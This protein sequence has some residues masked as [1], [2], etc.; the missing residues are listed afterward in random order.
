M[1]DTS[2]IARPL[3]RAGPARHL[4]GTSPLAVAALLAVVLGLALRL[5]A[6]PDMPFWLDEAWTGAVIA[7]D[8]FA[9]ML[10]RALLDPNAPLYFVVTYGWS[11]LF[12]LS[13]GAVRS[14][15][16]LFGMLAPLLALIPVKGIPRDTRYLWCVLLALW[17]PGLF[18]SQEARC[19]TLLLFVATACTIAYVRLLQQPD[20]RRAALWAFLGT[21]CLLTHYHAFVLLGLQGL[22]YLAMHRGRALR[23]WP[24]ALLFAPAFSWSF[25]HLPLVVRHAD[26]QFAWYDQ[27]SVA[28]LPDVMFFLLGGLPV[29]VGLV[30]LALIPLIVR[31]PSG[32]TVPEAGTSQTPCWVAAA[33][34]ALGTIIV[35]AVA[36]L[37]TSFTN[38]YLIAF[39][40]GLMLGIAMAAV[41]LG[42]RHAIIP[43]GVALVFGATAA[44][45]AI[46][47]RGQTLKIYNFQAA[48]DMLMAANVRNLVFLYD[49]PTGPLFPPDQLAALGG[50]FLKRAGSSAVVEGLSVRAGDDPNALVLAAASGRPQGG[51]LWIYDT[52]VRGTA[53]TSHPP[54]IEQIDPAWQCRQFGRDGIGVVACIRR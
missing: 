36:M 21:L 30:S 6:L 24:A 13:N 38:R 46:E 11:L 52:A 49:N 10:H 27:L 8:S 23:T 51:I 29:V 48:S 45:R 15:S 28:G 37:S 26:P 53:A 25:I 31:S 4:L 33:T 16:L 35:L 14:V 43:I 47:V 40:P 19:Y 5:F 1:T 39:V 34:A 20:L 9:T 3:R 44:T 7:S 32:A 2:S 17:S 42:R 18:Y 22:A 54:R 50:F 41:A 12:G